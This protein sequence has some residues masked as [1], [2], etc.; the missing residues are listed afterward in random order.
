M[1]RSWC[2][3]SCRGLVTRGHCT[4]G[5]RA[6]ICRLPFP[7]SFSNC[8]CLRQ[9]L[10]GQVRSWT[11]I[12]VKFKHIQKLLSFDRLKLVMSEESCLRNNEEVALFKDKINPRVQRC[13]H[14]VRPNSRCAVSTPDG[15][16]AGVSLSAGTGWS[17]FTPVSTLAVT[18]RSLQPR[19]SHQQHVSLDKH[20]VHVSL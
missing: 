7:N 13:V 14:C 19:T 18:R 5:I 12:F 8:N 3:A 2:G 10:V 9:V 1:V 17:G 20:P 16:L 15:R 11:M 4:A 6:G